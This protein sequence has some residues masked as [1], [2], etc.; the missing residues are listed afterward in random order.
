MAQPAA[1]AGLRQTMGEAS[2]AGGQA[3]PRWEETARLV[4]RMHELTRDLELNYKL[5]L[6]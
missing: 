1:D 2:W 3:L 4:A 6:E 5:E